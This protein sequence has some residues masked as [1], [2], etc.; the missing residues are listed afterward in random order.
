MEAIFPF[1]FTNPDYFQLFPQKQ[2]CLSMSLLNP[3]SAGSGA[4][5]YD[6]PRTEI[7]EKYIMAVD[8]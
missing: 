1:S 2:I 4:D 3:Y 5:V 7:M 6:A 8:P